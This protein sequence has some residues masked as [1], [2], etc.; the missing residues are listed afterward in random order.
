MKSFTFNIL[1]SIILIGIF[2]AGCSVKEEQDTQK[3]I[4][5][6]SK[7]SAHIFHHKGVLDVKPVGEHELFSVGRD[8]LIILW[9]ADSGRAVSAKR[10][11]DFPQKIGFDS[12]RSGWWIACKSGTLYRMALNALT[13]QETIPTILSD[14]LQFQFHP[15]LSVFFGATGKGLF[16]FNPNDAKIQILPRD[17]LG[18]AAIAAHPDKPLLAV[19]SGNR[20]QIKDARTMKLFNSFTLPGYKEGKNKERFVTF[21]GDRGIVATYGENLWMGNWQ[22]RVMQQLPKNHHAPITA[23]AVLSNDS[24][25]ATGSMDK[26]VKLWK[27]PQGNLQG[28]FYGHF[29]TITSLAFA[30]SGRKLVSGSEDGSM[31][32]WNLKTKL[33]EKR[34]GSLEVA[35]RNPWKLTVKGVRYARSFKVGSEEYNVSDSKTRLIKVN[36]EI[37]NIGLAD[38]MFFSSNLFLTAPDQTRFHCV[39]L[40]N[41]VA[42]APKAYFKR[43]IASGKSL[44]GN[45]IF[46]IEP[47]YKKYTITY[48][49]LNPISLK[50]F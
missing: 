15:M 2:V 48:E 22:K 27:W 49:T 13:V 24:L 18:F 19:F 29:L 23:L 43:R 41:Y 8:S 50:N 31:I 42:L 39:G 1:L 45:F 46:I 6:K 47:P 40:E 34:L 28:S 25:I 17:A 32:I 35:M 14:I 38:N 10:L 12:K 16:R 7:S 9:N 26:S 44:K 30:D 3:S 20:I 37:K 33:M 4:A 21:V 5:G 36:A 11:P